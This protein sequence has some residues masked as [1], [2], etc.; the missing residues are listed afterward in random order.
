[1]HSFPNS[2]G[3][4]PI[5][6]IRLPLLDYC[7]SRPDFAAFIQQVYKIKERLVICLS[8]ELWL[9][10]IPVL[11]IESRFDLPLAAAPCQTVGPPCYINISSLQEMW[12]G[13]DP[14]GMK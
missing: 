7:G 4:D 9:I 13:Q 11:T 6:F 1:M 2:G 12:R 10:L 5:G 14:F 3:A 8:I